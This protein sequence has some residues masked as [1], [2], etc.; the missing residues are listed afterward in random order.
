MN[1]EETITE[2]VT[3][4]NSSL[5]GGGVGYMGQ[6]PYRGDL[7][8]LFSEAYRKGYMNRDANPYLS[9]DGLRGFIIARW[10][11]GTQEQRDKLIDRLCTM[12]QE[13]RYAWDKYEATD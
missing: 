10:D 5:P 7:F 11:N 8:K 6:E 1:A 2:V 13:W 9:A 12:W 3:F 4:L